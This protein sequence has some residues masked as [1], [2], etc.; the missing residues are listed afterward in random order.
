LTVDVGQNTEQWVDFMFNNPYQATAGQVLLA[1]IYA[2]FTDGLD[3]V[4][5]GASGIS[6]P[7][8]TMLQDVDGVQGDPGTWYYTTQTSMVRLKF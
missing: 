8:E 2:E 1:T 4:V 3:S 7:G 6:N 5:I